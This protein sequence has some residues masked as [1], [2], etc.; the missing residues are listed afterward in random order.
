MLRGSAGHAVD[1]AVQELVLGGARFLEREVVREAVPVQ[2]GRRSHEVRIPLAAA[3]PA[4]L[5]S[6]PTPA[7]I[8]ASTLR[9]S[10]KGRRS[11]VSASTSMSTARRAVSRASRVLLGAQRRHRVD[12]GRPGCRQPARQERGRPEQRQRS[13]ENGWVVGGAAEE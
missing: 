1:L 3:A 13:G 9:R 8:S 6:R 10:A 2:C 4:R 7:S 11:G 5:R 12:A